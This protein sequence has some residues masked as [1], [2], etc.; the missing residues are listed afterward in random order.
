MKNNLKNYKQVLIFGVCTGVCTDD[1]VLE[2]A[3]RQLWD[4]NEDV[5][6]QQP[7]Q[8]KFLTCC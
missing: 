4:R 2:K 3:F 5:W 8:P 7:C 1:F 6:P